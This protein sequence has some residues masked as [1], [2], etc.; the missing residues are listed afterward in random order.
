[1]KCR[2]AIWSSI[3]RRGVV[4]AGCAMWLLLAGGGLAKAAEISEAQQLWKSGQY[5]ACLQ[6]A[7]KAIAEGE[8][9][10]SWFVL[11]IQCAMTLGRYPD[12][13]KT[14]D[15]GLEKYGTSV[16][17]RWLG[18]EVCRYNGRDRR[19]KQLLDEIDR[20]VE[21]AAWRYSDPESQLVLGRH[22]LER[23]ADPKQILQTLYGNIKR[24][25]PGYAPVFV[26]CGQLALEKNDYQLAADEFRRAIELDPADPD[27]H[28]GLARAYAPSDDER[29]SAAIQAAL[30][31]NPHH[32]DSLLFLVDQYVDGERYDEAE[33]LLN[34]IAAVNPRQ[35]LAWA[36]RA[37]IAHLRNDADEEQRCRREALS[38]WSKNPAVDH[39]IGRKLSQKYRFAEGAEY[40]RRALAMDPAFLPAQMQL[41]QDLLRLGEEQE[42]WRLANEVFQRDRYNVVAHNL[43]VLQENLGRYATLQRGG[44]VVRM[45]AREASVY[46]QDVLDLL[47]EARDQ[48]CEKYQV[49]LEGPIV[50]EIFHRQEDFAIRTFGL[51][52]GAGFLG[53]CFGRVVTMNSPQALTGTRSNWRSVLWHEF[54]HVVTLQKTRNKMPRW[55]S[56]GISVYEERQADARWGQ[57]MTPAFR[58]MIL[59]GELVPVSRLSAAFLRPP[60]PLHLQLAY[61]QSSLVVEYL[62]EQHGLDALRRVLDDLAIG[63]PINEALQRHIG[64][65]EVV[66]RQFEEFARQRAQRYGESVDWTEPDLPRDADA[67]VVAAWLDAHPNNYAALK[68]YAQ[69]LVGQQ[70]W[71]AAQAPLEQLIE[72]VPDDVGPD[73]AYEMLALVHRQLGEAER[74]QAVLEQYVRHS[75]EAADALNRLMQLSAAKQQWQ[76]VAEYGR[77]LLA[78]EPMQRPQHEM[79][80]EAAE[81]LGDKDLALRSLKALAQ[82]GPI[83]PADVQYRLAR[84]L[85][86]RGDVEAAKRHVLQALEH[87]PRF[88]DAHRLLLKLVDRSADGQGDTAASGQRAETQTETNKEPEK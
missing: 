78:V 21:Q 63:M 69:L 88:R 30:K 83:D 37:V 58:R 26:A 80:A 31:L 71:R 43:V 7:D 75:A 41:S 40:Q 3:A 74:E 32:I 36:Y 24:L 52:G 1:M 70:R 33:K 4:A 10:E 55:L 65:L 50:V 39:L 82:L 56:E 15:E 11:K 48:L 87:A 8:W 61:Y 19:A 84:L 44:F 62:I 49:Q 17:L 54:C 68:L 6:Y 59:A 46:G 45:E 81:Q 72:L 57:R 12:A 77:Q 2:R 16:R 73:C 28:C 29:S 5:E 85:H 34:R 20:L 35:P 18:A 76:A 51:P 14:L 64:S 42:G 47:E 60:S 66:D 23:G 25:M 22:Y 27:A 79:L 86:E 53:V 9:G 13:L 67:E 38:G